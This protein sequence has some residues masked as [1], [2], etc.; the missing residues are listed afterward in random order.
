MAKVIEGEKYNIAVVKKDAQF[1]L[2]IAPRE[3]YLYC[4]DMV[5]LENGMLGMCILVDEYVAD[6]KVINHEMVSGME[7]YRV[8][9]RYRKADV[10]WPEEKEDEDYE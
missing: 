7:A 6:D 8:I 9:C 1:A 5:E 2:G 10:K 3:E 4:G